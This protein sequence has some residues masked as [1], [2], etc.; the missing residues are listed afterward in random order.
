MAEQSELD[1]T[2]SR[3]L[4]DI[5]KLEEQI[6]DLISLLKSDSSLVMKIN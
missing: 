5:S 2:L 6:S 4:K 1:K 3:T